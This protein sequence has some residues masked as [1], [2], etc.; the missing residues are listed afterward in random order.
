MNGSARF[1]EVDRAHRLPSHAH[2]G[3][4][5]AEIV[6]ETS[7][8]E[9]MLKSSVPASSS[10]SPTTILGH[11]HYAMV[12]AVGY[13]PLWTA[14][15][16]HL[17]LDK[18][19]VRFICTK[20]GLV[21][22]GGISALLSRHYPRSLV[23]AVVIGLM[24]ANTINAGADLLAI[25]LASTFSCRCRQPPWSPRLRWRSSR[26]RSGFLSSDC[27]DFQMAHFRV[28]L[29]TLA[30]SFLPT[31][32]GTRRCGD[33][34]QGSASTARFWLRSWP[35]RGRRFLPTSS[36]GRRAKRWRRKSPGDENTFGR[37]RR[38]RRRAQVRRP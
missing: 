4:L 16:V 17:S 15:C 3:S 12:G 26:C 11:R 10:H 14:S 31:P 36:S 30:R 22:R 27:R 1:D 5:E 9:R 29:P 7:H 32:I 24:V 37:G 23:Y 20:I 13:A 6:R 34:P 21:E 2:G 8:L 28:C 38:H 19:S 35:F 33:F 25:G 18:P